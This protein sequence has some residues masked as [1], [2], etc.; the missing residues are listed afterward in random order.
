MQFLFLIFRVV[1]IDS[2]KSNFLR[3]TTNGMVLL[4]IICYHYY[5]KLS[6]RI[7]KKKDGSTLFDLFCR[8][9]VDLSEILLWSTSTIIYSKQESKQQM[10]NQQLTI[11]G[12]SA[13][14]KPL[15][16]ETTF[17]VPFLPNM[18]ITP[19]VMQVINSQNILIM[20]LLEQQNAL[21]QR[22]STSKSSGSD[23][24]SN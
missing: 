18:G 9:W 12:S 5:C 1:L 16:C 6:S 10:D 23:S 22:L 14:K 2:I 8:I 21:Y 13:F 7:R 20:R 3:N 24:G 11:G 15:L 17:P 19:E 4:S